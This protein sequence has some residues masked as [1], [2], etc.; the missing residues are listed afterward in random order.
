MERINTIR[1]SDDGI[2]I[3]ASAGGGATGAAVGVPSAA[4]DA[5]PT[6]TPHSRIT[7]D[8]NFASP[9]YVVG[10]VPDGLDDATLRGATI[11]DPQASPVLQANI[12]ARCLVMGSP[13]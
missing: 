2:P 6:K 1:T 12:E 10:E 4:N 5:V 11:D 7:A 8:F 9:I 13:R 3:S